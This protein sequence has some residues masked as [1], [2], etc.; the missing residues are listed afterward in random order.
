MTQPL[1]WGFLGASRIGRKA[2]AP[3]MLA[4]GQTLVAV[5]ARDLSRARDFADAFAAPR[6]YGSY[7]EVI[8]DPEVQ[9][10]YI[11]LTN[12]QHLPWTLAALRAGKHVLCE[13]PLALNAA[14]V[15]AMQQAEAET[16]SRVME[17]YCHIFHP[18]FARLRSLIA[19]GAIGRLLA[20][21]ASF[22]GLM[23]E[24]DFRWQ[25]ALG[26][27]ALY[28]LGVY[29]ISL[30]RGLAG[31]ASEV[32]AVQTKRH[33]VDATLAG[34]MSFPA[35]VAGQFLCSFEGDLSQQLLVQGTAGRIVL[36]WPFSTRGRT[37]SLT[38]NGTTERFDLFDPYLAMVTH[39]AAALDAGEAFRFPLAASLAQARTLDALFD[40]AA[41]GRTVRL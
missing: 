8:A 24:D 40:A 14:E 16:G 1:R 10:V 35:G 17:A 11:A 37:T 20:L 5:G 32:S 7:A 31:E 30:M 3:A 19:E 22:V 6:A 4:A 29:C 15:S 21:Q 25:P 39:F 26:G 27:G 18:Q 38:L 41:S 23:P 28:D 34:Q 36:D 9:A 13:K 2:L 12:E 33:G